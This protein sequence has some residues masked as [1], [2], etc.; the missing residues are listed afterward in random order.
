MIA[1]FACIGCAPLSYYGQAVVGHFDLM[2]R[3]KP[4]EERLAEKDLA[5]ELRARLESVLAIRAFA[6]TELGLPDNGSYRSYADLQR[7]HV[8]WNVVATP[9]F[10]F[11]PRESCF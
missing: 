7:S 2:A 9:E 1:V 4:I 10:S 11:K 8:I 6:S 3:A 5:P